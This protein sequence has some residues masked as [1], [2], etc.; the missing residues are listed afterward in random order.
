MF[1]LYYFQDKLIFRAVAIPEDSVYHFS[2][3]Y[4]ECT[5]AFDKGTS[6]NII[7]FTTADTV[8]KGLVL[9][10]HGN[11]EKTTFIRNFEKNS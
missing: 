8:Q 1:I 7:Q 3:P 9:Y 2:Q 6:F 5:I 10:F 4:K 11:K